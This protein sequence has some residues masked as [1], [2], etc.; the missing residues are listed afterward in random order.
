MMAIR[1]N[2][3]MLWREENL[4]NCNPPLDVSEIKIMAFKDLENPECDPKL[5]N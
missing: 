5:T 1:K 2:N 3:F 4:T